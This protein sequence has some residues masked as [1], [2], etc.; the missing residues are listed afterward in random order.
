MARFLS[1]HYTLRDADGRV[2][3]TS[4]GGEPLGCIEG[5]GEIVPGLERALRA[6][7]PGEQRKVALAPEQG[8]GPREAELIHRVPRAQLPFEGEIAVGD[9]FRTGAD[10][11]APIV[12]VTAI[13]GDMVVLDGNH[14]LAGQ[15]LFF[16]VE[17]VAARAATQDELQRV[18]APPQH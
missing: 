10:R 2:L 9:Q 11:H 3:D 6:L 5:A 18:S 15:T 13:E 7:R 1:F 4:R 8:Y 17:L 16:D 14:P 12:T